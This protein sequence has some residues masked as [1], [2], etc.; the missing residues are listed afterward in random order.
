MTGLPQ[1]RLTRFLVF[2]A[3]VLLLN[4]DLFIGARGLF[5]DV[6]WCEYPRRAFLGDSLRNGVFPFWDSFTTPGAPAL[7]FTYPFYHPLAILLGLLFRYSVGVFLFEFFLTGLVCIW[8]MYLWTRRMDVP[9][10]LAIAAAVA[11]F[12]SAPLVDSLSN[13]NVYVSMAGVPWCFLGLELVLRGGGG[14]DSW[15]GVFL[16]SLFGAVLNAGG[17]IALNY[18]LGI[19]LALYALARM[20]WRN[21]PLTGTAVLQLALVVV[22]VACLLALPLLELKDNLPRSLG[23]YRDPAFDANAGCLAAASWWTLWIPNAG[24]LHGIYIGRPEQMY[25]GAALALAL[26]CAL[27]LGR[28]RSLDVVLAG[29]ALLVIHAAR[30]SEYPLARAVLDAVPVLGYFRYRCLWGSV[31]AFA[32]ITVSVRGLNRLMDSWPDAVRLRRLV[33]ATVVVTLLLVLAYAGSHVGL[34][35]KPLF[36]SVYDVV[37]T[38]SCVGLACAALAMWWARARRTDR[39][40][41]VQRATTRVVL[42]LVVLLFAAGWSARF[43]GTRCGGSTPIDDPGRPAGQPSVELNVFQR[44]D[45][46][47]FPESPHRLFAADAVHVTLAAALLLALLWL[48]S[49]SAEWKKWGVVMLV[50]VDLLVAGHRY[51]QGNR[52]WITMQKY[53]DIPRP[54]DVAYVGNVREGTTRQNLALMNRI[55]VMESYGPVVNMQMD[56]FKKSEVGRRLCSRLVWCFPENTDL[57]LPEMPTPLDGGVIQNVRLGA[58]SLDAAIVV[59]R[60][61]LLVWADTWAPG[62][63]VRVNGQECDLLK[64]AGL[65]KGVR[66]SPGASRVE[67]IYIPRFRT[68]GLAGLAVGLFL[69]G[70]WSWRTWGGRSSK[71]CSA[72]PTGFV[73]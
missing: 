4:F 24:Y 65:L 43:V 13:L 7:F 10:P 2:A 42:L 29:I 15:L 70:A 40:E 37:V 1:Q 52:Y 16:L 32:L 31:V 33:T 30:S 38:L 45:R 26:P 39:P 47:Q 48:P 57:A 17:Y 61:A 3:A 41:D 21:V 49:R 6:F 46:Q 5:H 60:P 23:A 66:L 51:R 8:G 59:D 50:L 71:N 72:V 20:P 73:R 53:G 58:D 54:P 62:W 68:L 36:L 63:R 35:V 27:L 34:P 55:P 19:L 67:F 44:W 9:I 12:G 69:L 28:P 22:T 64:P 11:Y 14:R 25:I 18:A 56:E